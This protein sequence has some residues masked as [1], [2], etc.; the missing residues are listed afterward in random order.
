LS[1]TH[2]K[3]APDSNEGSTTPADSMRHPGSSSSPPPEQRACAGRSPG[4]TALLAITSIILFTLYCTIF[5][6]P[7]K[8]YWDTYIVAASTFMTDHPARFVIRGGEAPYRCRLGGKLPDDLVD[9]EDYGIIT[10]DRQIGEAI[11][12]SSLYRILGRLGFRVL[13][14]LLPVIAFFFGYLVASEALGLS[15]VPA[16]ASGLLMGGN[17]YCLSLDRLNP[18]MYALALGTAL[19]YLLLRPL[20]S[21]RPWFIIGLLYGIMGGIKGETIVY[22]PAVLGLALLEPPAASGRGNTIRRRIGNLCQLVGGAALAILPILYWNS[23]AFGTSVIHPSQHPGFHG[24]R[25]TFAHSFL[26]MELQF[27]GLLNYP[28]HDKLVRTPHFA[29]PVFLSFPFTVFKSFGAIL[30]ACV[31]LGLWALWCRNR[32]QALFLL[33]WALP[34]FLLFAFQENWEEV[35]MT[36]ILLLFAPLVLFMAE[37]LGILCYGELRK[38]AAVVLTALTICIV[39]LTRLATTLD[40]PEDERWYV[41]FPKAVHSE[42]G[43]ARL[44]VEKRNDWEFFHTREGPGELADEK[45]RMASGNLLPSL[46][47]PLALDPLAAARAVVE[48]AGNYKVRLL[49][50][51]RLIYGQ[52]SKP[53]A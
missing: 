46:Y 28:F 29:F 18:N 42:S 34:V 22:G 47:L 45:R 23:Y 50:T 16:L 41:R 15:Y 38:S 31:P 36:F 48:E 32:R 10:K 12:L 7:S 2:L 4:Q 6:P 8:G 30:S 17:P 27:N 37:G 25:P 44:P 3:D 19:I 39:G 52:K 51:W 9:P 33:A 53:G 5:E 20:S 11:T 40:L 14:A 21:R 1:E 49:D 43:L 26:G 35:K 13:F 24:Y